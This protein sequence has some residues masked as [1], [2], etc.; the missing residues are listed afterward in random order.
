MD[1]MEI[2]IQVVAQEALRDLRKEFPHS[3]FDVILRAFAPAIHI[4]PRSAPHSPLTAKPE[5]F[6]FEEFGIDTP[7]AQGTAQYL[8]GTRGDYEQTFSLITELKGI[9]VLEEL[10]QIIGYTHYIHWYQ[11]KKDH[12]EFY[13]E[14]ERNHPSMFSHFNRKATI[15]ELDNAIMGA[16]ERR[17]RC[18]DINHHLQG[19]SG[20]EDKLAGIADWQ[21]NHSNEC[22]E[23]ISGYMP[24]WKPRGF[25]HVTVAE[26]VPKELRDKPGKIGGKTVK[27][28]THQNLNEEFL[29][30]CRDA[31]GEG[32]LDIYNTNPQR[33]A[34]LREI[35]YCTIIPRRYVFPEAIKLI[36]DLEGIPLLKHQVDLTSNPDYRADIYA[37]FFRSSQT[38]LYKMYRTYNLLPDI[39][40]RSELKREVS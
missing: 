8:N 35:F 30:S 11:N 31:F 39:P 37:T 4:K 36:M 38:L 15:A 5:D 6:M 27:F 12:E 14:L 20:V 24:E 25:Q 13:K 1:D 16:I 22:S 28:G 23:R 10:A 34:E 3:E 29:H 21:M 2:Q 7:S 32:L 9:P 17:Y 18:D 26:I 33:L 19:R 40:L